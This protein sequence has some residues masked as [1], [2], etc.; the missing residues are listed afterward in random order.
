MSEPGVSGLAWD[1]F[2]PRGEYVAVPSRR[3]SLIVASRDPA[4]LRY[5]AASVLSVPPGAG[6][7]PSLLV[8]IGLRVF[9]HLG[10]VLLAGPLAGPLRA[11]TR[12][13]TTA[14]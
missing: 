14:G 7:V 6:P 13:V 1:E 2:L 12:F 9:R 4:V 8:T 3:R 11:R 5:L 10:S